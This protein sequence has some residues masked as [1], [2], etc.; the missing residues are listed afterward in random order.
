MAQPPDFALLL[1]DGDSNHVPSA[2]EREQ[3]YKTPADYGLT[4]KALSSLANE[5]MRKADRKAEKGELQTGLFLPIPAIT[6]NACCVR[7]DL[8]MLHDIRSSTLSPTRRTEDLLWRSRW[9]V[10]QRVD[11]VKHFSVQTILGC[12]KS[13]P[14]RSILHM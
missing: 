7:S 5:M 2:E 8:Q 10:L 6:E 3:G 13:E 12:H 4:P 1:T 14:F 11:L 9:L